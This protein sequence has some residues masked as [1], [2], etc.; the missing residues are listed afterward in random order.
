MHSQGACSLQRIF[1]NPR[2]TGLQTSGSCLTT[3]LLALYKSETCMF[4]HIFAVFAPQVQIE[5]ES[6]KS[7][8]CKEG[9]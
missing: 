9:E 2:L 7:E 4:R 6:P 5:L 8:Q 3:R 1:V